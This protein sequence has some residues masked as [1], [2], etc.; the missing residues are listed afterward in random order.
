MGVLRFWGSVGVWVIFSASGTLG[1]NV[2]AE[3]LH[4]WGFR[5][6]CGVECTC[7]ASLTTHSSMF[8]GDEWP[9]LSPRELQ[10]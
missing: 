8:V 6:G 1:L 2:K 9:R 3:V 5:G 4:L 7:R 10:L